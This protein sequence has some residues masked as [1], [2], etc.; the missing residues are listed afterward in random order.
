MPA[1]SLA[2]ITAARDRR[3]A[4][5][6]RAGQG[7]GPE[8][9]AGLRGLVSEPGRQRS[10]LL[11][12]Y[13]NRNLE[14]DPRHPGRAR[15]PDRARRS[16]HGQPTHFLPRRQWGVFTIT[17]P[18]DFGEKQADVDDRRER[19]DD[20]CRWASSR[21]RRSSRSRT[22]RSATRRRYVR[23]DPEGSDL[24]RVRRPRSRPRIAQRSASPL[25]ARTPRTTDDGRSSAG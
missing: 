15:Q 23:L 20:Q 12:G 22:R 8:R 4:A 18:K 10:A 24:P 6:A 2:C 11:I 14:A 25:T 19:Q 7:I 1:R 13:I 5:A 3:G 16:R 21:L 17:V 9:H